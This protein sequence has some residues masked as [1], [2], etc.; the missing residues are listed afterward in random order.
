MQVLLLLS[1]LLSALTGAFVAPRAAEAGAEQ[2][3]AQSAAP[4]RPVAQARQALKL[5]AAPCPAV[6]G[7]ESEPTP[8]R[9]GPIRPAALSSICLIE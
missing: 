2:M 1:A 6:S 9:A 3:Q 8:L 4:A 5:T 7:L